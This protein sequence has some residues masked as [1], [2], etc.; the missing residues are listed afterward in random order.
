MSVCPMI[1]KV[2]SCYVSS[3]LNRLQTIYSQYVLLETIS[4]SHCFLSILIN[5]QPISHCKI[6]AHYWAVDRNDSILDS[7]QNYCLELL[8]S[9]LI[10]LLTRNNLLIHWMVDQSVKFLRGPFET[11][12]T[13]LAS[14]CCCTATVSIQLPSLHKTNP[15]LF[16]FRETS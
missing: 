11:Y 16:I 13:A 1:V 12:V 5:E 8:E 9:M 15:Q 2:D 14:F 3:S 7:N 4:F 10:N 6:D